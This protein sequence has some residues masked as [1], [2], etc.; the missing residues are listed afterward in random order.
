MSKKKSKFREPLY[1]L[2]SGTLDSATKGVHL[3]QDELTQ[4]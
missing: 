3:Q 4:H 1:E 2:N